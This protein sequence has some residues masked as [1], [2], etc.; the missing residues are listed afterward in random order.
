MP[1]VPTSHSLGRRCTPNNLG[2]MPPL[3]L[4]GA[5]LGEISCSSMEW[6]LLCMIMCRFAKGNVNC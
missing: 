5:L 6:E 3:N 4:E 2:E 1:M